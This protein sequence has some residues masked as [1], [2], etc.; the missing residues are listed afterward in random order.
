MCARPMLPAVA[1]LAF[2][3]PAPAVR[4]EATSVP[5]TRA[6]EA[7][8]TRVVARGPFDVEIR[9]G[10]AA[11][12][13]VF[14]APGRHEL[15][16]TL[17]KDGSLVIEPASREQAR[18]DVRV[19][20]TLPSLEGI[21]LAG[22]GSVRAEAGPE[23]RD[24]GLALRGSGSLAWSGATRSLSAEVDGSG[25]LRVDGPA[26]SL[27]AAVSGSGNLAYRGTAKSVTLAVAGSG[28]ARLDGRGDSLKVATTG[29]GRVDA[30]GFAAR[31]VEISTAGS[32]DV[33]VRVAGG[34]VTATLVGSGDVEWSGEGRVG[35]VQVLGSGRF[36]HL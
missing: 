8:F 36:R 27:H 5:Q 10:A 17:V 1:V 2:L 4:A 6:V 31:D 11:S 22:S 29:S 33:A 23:P 34:S 12:V 19:S 18:E 35:G 32:G 16:R 15:V 13:V 21:E 9:G 24:V 26:P 30:R 7:A 25:N 20:V 3:G 28:D 14:A